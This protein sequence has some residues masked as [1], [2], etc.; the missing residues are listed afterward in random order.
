[1][2]LPMKA[3]GVLAA[4]AV[5]ILATVSVVDALADVPTVSDR[6]VERRTITAKDLVQIRDVGDPYY[7][8]LSVSPDG[9]RLAFQMRQADLEGNRY[10]TSWHIAQTTG[11]QPLVE[12]GDGGEPIFF[13][14]PSGIRVGT[15][16]VEVP[17]WSPDGR[18][19]VYRRMQDGQIQL[20]RSRTDGSIQERLTDNHADVESF[21]WSADGTRIFFQ[22]DRTR[23]FKAQKD[24]DEGERGYL[25]DGSFVPFY[26]PRPLWG[27]CPPDN[28]WSRVPADRA[29]SLSLWVYDLRTGLEQEATEREREEYTR[30]I[31]PDRP[32]FLPPDRE[33]RS[34][35]RSADG[36]S[37]AWLENEDPETYPG[38]RAPLTVFASGPSEMRC[39]AAECRGHFSKLWWSSDADELYLIRQEG[40]AL[41]ETAFY[42]W[43]PGDEDVRL[44][45]RTD[46]F[47]KDCHPAGDR[48]VCL[49]ESVASP[50]HI[51]AIDLIDGDMETLI[52]PNPVYGEI[53]FTRV[54]KLTWQ[55]GFGNETFG[56]LVYPKDY[57]EGRRYPL[58][59]V[60]YRSRGFLRGGTGDEYPIHLL[61]ANGFAVL[62]FDRPSDWKN[63]GKMPY[64]WE[65]EKKEWN[66]SYEKRRALTALETIIDR[67]VS[68]GIIDPTQVGITGL[69]DGAE[70]LYF[71]LIHTDRF[72]AASAS[73]GSWEQVMYYLSGETFYRDFL[74]YVGLGRPAGPD[75]ELWADNAVS[76][77]ADKINAPLLIQ[78]SDHELTGLGIETYVALKEEAKPVEMRVFPDEYHVKWQPQ[79]RFNIYRR[80]V[81]WMQFWLQGV[82]DP[83]PVDPE[84]YARW[85]E[86]R[87]RH[88]ANQQAL[89]QAQRP[90]EPGQT[91]RAAAAELGG[92]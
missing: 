49:Y 84:Q 7:G 78:L 46:D 91:S 47:I 66:D 6:T 8:G 54:E 57:R 65:W 22:V 52:D 69:S 74:P 83:D 3:Y 40:V 77:N 21:Q 25:M 62:S 16:T 4:F 13:I 24:R 70:T 18:W 82:E 12:V 92:E 58:V 45:L 75:T 55:D 41:S 60:Q 33:V 32:G 85:R 68:E 51:V 14:A 20:W 86:L 36:G 9:R 10:N 35:Y 61:A 79:H 39:P 76:L 15:L 23:A 34:I 56:H 43:R 88:E 37:T 19:I 30:L 53:E 87:E 89:E 17:K 31:S 81:Q 63:M 5:T 64:G 80:N 71:M 50:R 44:I 28:Q 72:A 26:A 48:A 42:G 38:S 59:I 29:C 1:M 67:L 90:S 11:G 73:S 2:V 27:S